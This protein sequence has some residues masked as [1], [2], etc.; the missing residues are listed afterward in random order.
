[1]AEVLSAEELGQVLDAADAKYFEKGFPT[2]FGRA[3]V[4]VRLLAGVRIG[5]YMLHE[6]T[7]YLDARQI[8][9]NMPPVLHSAVFDFENSTVP[10]DEEIDAM[11]ADGRAVEKVTEDGE[12]VVE[13]RHSGDEKEVKFKVN[14]NPLK[15]PERKNPLTHAEVVAWA[16]IQ[17]AYE[18]GDVERAQLIYDSCYQPITKVSDQEGIDSPAPTMQPVPYKPKKM[19]IDHSK[20][21]KGISAL[22]AIAYGEKEVAIDGFTINGRQVLAT[23]NEGFFTTFFDTKGGNTEQLKKIEETVQTLRKDDRAPA[24]EDKGYLWFTSGAIAEGMSATTAGT[25]KAS[26][27]PAS[28]SLV[29]AGLLALQSAVY[30]TKDENGEV[31]NSVNILNCAHVENYEIEGKVYE[32]VWGFPVAGASLFDLSAQLATGQTFT[33]PLLESDKPLTTDESGYKRYLDDIFNEIRGKLWRIDK[34]TGQPSPTRTEKWTVRRSYETMRADRPGIFETF[35]PL[36]DFRKPTSKQK[37][38]VV[39]GLNDMMIKMANMELH[40]E[41]RN[42]MRVSIEAHSERNAGRGKGKGAW[43]TLVVT[44]TRST[45]TPR[46]D[47][48]GE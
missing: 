21:M 38:K 27:T 26:Q 18:A 24:F 8:E 11:L 13:I 1:M 2:P 42:S 46:I 45:H 12:K 48:M 14:F 23:G 4:A 5:E 30:F 31:L 17:D 32:D 33:Y 35:Y 44:G 9:N 19:I 3:A 16:A 15:L 41:V 22:R 29:N 34:K 25:V 40:G 28:V 47:L 7:Y 6:G 36:A 37:R 10:D 43:E 39:Q 20:V